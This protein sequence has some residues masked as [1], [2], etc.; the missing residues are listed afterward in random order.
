MFL[1][2]F[3]KAFDMI[4]WGFF[5]TA[6]SKLGFNN[7][8]VNWVRA[9]YHL[10]SSAI[11]VN[12]V[13]GPDFYLARSIRQ[14]CP[15]VP[16]LFILATDLVGH[17]MEDPKYGVEGLHLPK[18]GCIRDQTFADDTTLYLQGSPTNMDKAQNVL[19]L[20]CQ[21]F[22]AKIGTNQLPSGPARREE[23]GPRAKR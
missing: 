10:A 19:K 7:T 20:F 14:G 22:G 13:I 21:T 8:R 12:G 3:E 9:L 18:G 6:L 11:K 1:L 17:M 16:Y 15:L 2:D 4:E 23:P 5:F